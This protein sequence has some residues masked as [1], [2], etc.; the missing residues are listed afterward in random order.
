[1][2]ANQT[3][4]VIYWELPLSSERLE[5]LTKIIEELEKRTVE[6]LSV[7]E[8]NVGTFVLNS[9]GLGREVI[10]YAY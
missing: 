3:I 10:S 4:P 6:D 8:A 2:N 9:L 1:L 5:E 7:N